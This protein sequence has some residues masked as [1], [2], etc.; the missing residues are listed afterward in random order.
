MK[1]KMVNKKTVAQKEDLF[2]KARKKIEQADKAGFE[3]VDKTRI[4]ERLHELDAQIKKY[5]KLK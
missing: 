1:C 2:L 3:S 5:K 4:N